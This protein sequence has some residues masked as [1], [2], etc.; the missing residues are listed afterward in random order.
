M[1]FKGFLSWETTGDGGW[2]VQPSLPGHRIIVPVCWSHAIFQPLWL[3][4]DT[5]CIEQWWQWDPVPLR[6]LSICNFLSAGT[7]HLYVQHLPLATRLEA[8]NGEPFEDEEWIVFVTDVFSPSMKAVRFLGSAKVCLIKL[9]WMEYNW[10][11]LNCTEQNQAELPNL[12]LHQGNVS[13]LL[14][15]WLFTTEQEGA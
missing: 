10:N 13:P 14:A 11:D 8:G 7:I 12:A 5:P 2:G 3:S 4:L 9:K 1:W 6:Q 15:N